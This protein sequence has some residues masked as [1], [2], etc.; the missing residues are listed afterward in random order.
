MQD[1]NQEPKKR[2][3]GPDPRPLE[4]LRRFRVS[5]Y[6]TAE[7]AT[8]LRQKAAASG[9]HPGAYLRSAGLTRLPRT[10]PAI[11]REAWL[12]LAKVAGN[13]NQY[14]SLLNEGRTTGHPPEII[15]ELRAQVQALR[16]SLLGLVDA[17][18]EEK[19]L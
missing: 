7:E 15:A 10:I 17:A 11:N 3:H 6:L 19:Q 13:L 14:Q 16:C 1:Q 2:R 9:L 12:S 5:V 4:E 8:A 18:E